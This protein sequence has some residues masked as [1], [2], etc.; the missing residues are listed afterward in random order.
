MITLPTSKLTTRRPLPKLLSLLS[1][2]SR[3][4]RQRRSGYKSRAPPTI[5]AGVKISRSTIEQ[6]AKKAPG[7]SPVRMGEHRC[8]LPIGFVE[9]GR[10]VVI[11]MRELNV[12]NLK[13]MVLAQEMAGVT[14]LVI[15]CFLHTWEIAG[16]VM[17]AFSE[18]V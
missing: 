10:K 15:T 8:K 18:C 14:S 1:L 12:P 7:K 17:V 4:L 9:A 13:C 5:R 2:R 16:R 11:E 3:C 6:G